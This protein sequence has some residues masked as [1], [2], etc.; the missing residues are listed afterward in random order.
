MSNTKF[1]AFYPS[2]PFWAGSAPSLIKLDNLDWLHGLDQTKQ[3]LLQEQMAEEVFSR[4][5]EQ[6][7]IRIARDGR[8]MVH[9]AQ[10]ETKA[11]KLHIKEEVDRWNEYLNYLN[12]FY[13]LLDS[14]TIEI[15]NLGYFNL[16]EVT[17]RDAFRIVPENGKIKGEAIASESIGSVFQLAR[18]LPIGVSSIPTM[19]M[20]EVI[21]LDVLEHASTL[22]QQV[23]SSPGLEKP[24][25]TLAKSL[26]EYKVGNYETSIVLSWFIVEEAVIHLWK[27]HLDKLNVDIKEKEMRIN[28]ARMDILTWRDFTISTV[29]N[30]LEL[31]NSLPYELFLDIN[32]VRRIRNDIVHRKGRKLGTTETQLALKTSRAMI[33]RIWGISFVLNLSYGISGF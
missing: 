3:N 22:F 20:R 21:S 12:A 25:A 30:L 6:S 2:R 18:N 19:M 29:S 11:S 15:M 33:E 1:T 23:F 4:T 10:L 13:L 5:E 27:S 7:Q 17:V 9:V 14:S 26:G 31:W 8:I 16:H 32:K 24:L 28:S